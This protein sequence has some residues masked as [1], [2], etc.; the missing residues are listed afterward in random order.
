MYWKKHSTKEI[1]KLIFNAIKK[2]INYRT[3]PI[4]GLPASYLDPI[5]FSNDAPFIKDCA[6]ISSLITNANHIGC[7]TI[8]TYE[9]PFIG[10]PE[11]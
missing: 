3:Q 6:Y 2:N 7:H 4:L 11:V 10:T 5:S 1:N 8:G 9:P